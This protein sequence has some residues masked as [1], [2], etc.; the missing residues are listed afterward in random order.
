LDKFQD[1]EKLIKI[2]DDI[3]KVY[4]YPSKIAHHRD[5]NGKYEK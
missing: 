3:E 1:E 2:I 5:E 4:E